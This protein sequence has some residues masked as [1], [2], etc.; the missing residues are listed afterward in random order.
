MHSSWSV[1]NDIKNELSLYP[2]LTD[3]FK[4]ALII[5]RLIVAFCV[6]GAV[7]SWV[8][9]AG[10][11][12]SAMHHRKTDIS[13]FKA[14]F[15]IYDPTVL[16]DKGLQERNRAFLSMASFFFFIV[17]ACIISVITGKN[18]LDL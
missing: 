11:T 14:Q 12:I 5:S 2:T 3:D 1:C 18:A 13:F 17:T 15:M 7:C 4:M 8:A 9:F 16:T 10:F 6:F